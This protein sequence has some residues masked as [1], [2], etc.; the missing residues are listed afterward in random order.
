VVDQLCRERR[1]ET[2]PTFFEVT[3]AAAFVAFSRARVDVAVLEVGLGGRFDATNVT[4]PLGVAITSIDLDHE[5]QLGRTLRE[6]AREKAGI[7]GPGS[8]AVVGDAR[9]EVQELLAD[10]CRRAGARYVDA[11]QGVVLGVRCTSDA[12]VVSLDTPVRHY[13]EIR[14]ALQGRHQARN[15]MTTVRLL[16]G[17]TDEGLEVGADAI[18]T[19]LRDAVW[20]GR[21]Q[22]I[23][24]PAGRLLLDAA[25]NPAAAQ[26]VAEYLAETH[27]SPI[28]L[29]LAAM[30][31]K[32]ADGILDALL[33]R[34]SLVVCTELTS[35]RALPASV[36]ADRVRARAPKTSVVIEPE[37]STAVQRALAHGDIACATGSIFL[38]GELLRAMTVSTDMTSTAISPH[39]G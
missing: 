20:R 5:A 26:A 34:A 4:T 10:S 29:V 25:H 27:P 16:E 37:P 24:L 14:L 13:G 38:A 22:W 36:L 23:S 39:A 32:D 1:L 33:P 17:L 9:R 3:T 21:L 15:A 30:R 35:E 2:S 31:D 19:G 6:I 12:T 11:T 18:A 28:P 7:I 8:V